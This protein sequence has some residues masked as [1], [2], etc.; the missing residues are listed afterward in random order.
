MQA[1]ALPNMPAYPISR[2][3]AAYAF[4][5]DGET[6]ASHMEIIWAKKD[7]EVPIA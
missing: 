1:E 2:D 5:G 6:E 7:G 3:S 4:L